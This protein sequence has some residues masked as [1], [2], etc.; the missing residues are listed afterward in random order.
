MGDYLY[1][2]PLCGGIWGG[3]LKQVLLYMYLRYVNHSEKLSSRNYYVTVVKLAARILRHVVS[4]PRFHS[5]DS[6]AL[7]LHM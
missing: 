2:R 6:P 5:D 1:Y 3:H 4:A 7:S